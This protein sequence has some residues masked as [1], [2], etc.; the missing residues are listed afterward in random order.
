MA[1]NNFKVFAGA[2]GADVLTQVDY[3]ALAALASGFSTGTAI[4]SQL[5]KVWRQSSIMASALAQFIGDQSGNNVIDDG[6]ITSIV[7]NLLL[8]VQT[9][10]LN[11]VTTMPPGTILHLP[12]ATPPVGT[13]AANGAL[14]L[15]TNYPDLWAEA[16]V[17]GNITATDTAWGATTTPGSYSPGD[18]ATTFRIPD[19]RGLFT[20]ALGSGSSPDTGRVLGSFQ[21]EMV[22]PH[23]HPSH[24]HSGDNLNGG[25]YYMDGAHLIAG[26]TGTNTGTETR[27]KN[28]SLLACIIY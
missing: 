23:T 5:N 11:A 4:S 2:V 18:G 15:R 20:R 16:Q 12:R 7:A 13:V 6:T 10:A 28:A 22:G 8:A 3:E 25:I 1:I 17:S 27:V 9:V 24:A 26:S 21:D 14:L 19:M